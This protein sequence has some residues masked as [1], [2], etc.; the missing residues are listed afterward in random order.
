MLKTQKEFHEQVGVREVEEQINADLAAWEKEGHGVGQGDRQR[1]EE[2]GRDH[3]DKCRMSAS[4][5]AVTS[6]H[7]WDP[8]FPRALAKRVA[9]LARVRFPPPPPSQ[10]IRTVFP[11]LVVSQRIQ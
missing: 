11:Y 5:P 4:D 2:E 8:C 6:D 1:R 10:R 7:R 3:R 9:R